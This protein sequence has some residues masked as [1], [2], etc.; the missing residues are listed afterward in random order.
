MSHEY[1]LSVV[2]PAYNGAEWIGEQ[3]DA[4][5]ASGPDQDAVEVVVVDNRSTDDTQAVVRAWSQGSGRPVRV[6]E[7]FDRAGEPHARNVGWQAARSERIAFCDADD[8]VSTGWATAMRR[9][10]HSERYLTGPMDT[11]TLNPPAA[12][13]MRGQRLF[14][15][16]PLLHDAVPFAHGAN[17]GYQRG[18]LAEVGGFDETFL[19]GCDIEIAVRC[20]RAGIDLG[21]A[22]DALVHY[23]FRT[24]WDGVFRQ[25]KA[26][27][28]SRHRIDALVPEV[29][30]SR[31]LVQNLRR[32]AWLV[33]SLPLL[34]GERRLHWAWVAG[35]VVGE[36]RGGLEARR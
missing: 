24:D 27:G 16:R 22:E 10:M 28:R 4:L 6:V 36:A 1:D 11:L 13:G 19:I 35:Q 33:K 7:A 15:Q 26:Y 2:I 29:A 17:M 30:R 5:A 3:L 21:W 20:W 8:R 9:G 31:P 12:A 23:R 18:A 34:A 32:S 14:S 25:A